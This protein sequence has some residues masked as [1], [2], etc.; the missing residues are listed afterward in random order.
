[1]DLTTR[2]LGLELSSPLMPGASPLADDLDA[3]RRLEDAGASAIVMRSLFEEQIYR[4]Y[5]GAQ[6]MLERYADG[7]AEALT[8]FPRTDEFAFGPEEYLKQVRRIKEAVRVPVIASLNGITPAGWL[9]YARLIEQAGAD[10]LEL[11]VYY[12]ATDRTEP[13]FAVEERTTQIVRTVKSAVSIPV[14]VK[15]SPFFSSLPHFADELTMAGADGLV[16]FNR[17][18]QPDIDIA[19]LE[20]V[21]ALQLSDSSELLLRL[22]WVAI[23]QPGVDVPIA[24][25]GG[26]HTATD[27]VKSIMAGASAVQVVSALLKNGPEYLKHLRV[28]LERFMTEHEYTSVSQMRGNMSLAKCP[29]P[30]AFSRANYMRILQ[31]WRW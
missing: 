9:T 24:I 6:A 23:V 13:G 1:M 17:F 29:D 21:P 28:G 16:F 7:S 11:N 25:S 2:Y 4:E 30:T 18:F 12:L 15:L 10:A 5:A 26:V 22:R 20:A 19:A 27:V 8:Y 3:V 14:A 31:T